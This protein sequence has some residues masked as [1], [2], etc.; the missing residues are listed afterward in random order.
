MVKGMA[1]EGKMV[2]RAHIVM[3]GDTKMITRISSAKSMIVIQ[4]VFIVPNI[5]EP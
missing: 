3:I 4:D 1:R 2:L 5:K